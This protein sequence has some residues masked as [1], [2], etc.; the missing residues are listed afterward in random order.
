MRE[1]AMAELERRRSWSEAVTS[2]ARDF[3]RSEALFRQAFQ[4]DLYLE[5]IEALSREHKPWLTDRPQ[6]R[7]RLSQLFI[8]GY[9]LKFNQDKYQHVAPGMKA[10]QEQYGIDRI[11]ELFA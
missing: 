5:E 7:E 6:E 11:R 10:A 3:T 8:R 1:K 9:R 2:L 4:T